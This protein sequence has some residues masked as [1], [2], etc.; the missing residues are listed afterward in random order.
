MSP[1]A[2]LFWFVVIAVI[3][4]LLCYY[5]L[6]LTWDA[7]LALA[8]II[9]GLLLALCYPTMTG[10]NWHAKE[11][12]G[13]VGLYVVVAVIASLYLLLWVAY[14]ATRYKRV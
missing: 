8:L 9:A 14:A 3:I 1:G 2:G 6:K 5:W 13:I 7:S 4:W 12:C 11:E 10:M